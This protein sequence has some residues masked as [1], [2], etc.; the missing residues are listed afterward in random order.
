MITLRRS[1]PEP[2][3]AA[4]SLAESGDEL[5]VDSAD[6]SRLLV[7]PVNGGWSIQQ[8]SLGFTT[9]LAVAVGFEDAIQIVQT[10]H[11]RLMI[12]A[13]NVTCGVPGVSPRR[14]D[15]ETRADGNAGIDSIPEDGIDSIPEER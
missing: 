2:A 12:A 4:A 9:D 3:R 5:V 8:V 7:S 13:R 14:R 6:E 1:L 11:N 10:A 15:G